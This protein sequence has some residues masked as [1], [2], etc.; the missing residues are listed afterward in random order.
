MKSLA[1][2]LALAFVS[3]APSSRAAA[4]TLTH[5]IVLVADMK[6]ARSA[7]AS[8]GFNV[9]P[10]RMFSPVWRTPSSHFEIARF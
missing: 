5:A 7:F 9:S 4:A 3:I 10:A 6:A 2:L 1:A 8:A